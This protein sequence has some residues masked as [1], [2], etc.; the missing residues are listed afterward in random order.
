MSKEFKSGLSGCKECKRVGGVCA[1][2]WVVLVNR[3]KFG[4]R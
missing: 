1:R 4:L 3:K 2:C